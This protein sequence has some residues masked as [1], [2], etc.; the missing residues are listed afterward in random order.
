MR[1]LLA[2]VM[3]AGLLLPAY[4]WGQR[5]IHPLAVKP[6]TKQARYARLDQYA[7]HLPEAQAA[8]LEKLA[9]SLASQAHTDDDKARLIF[10]WLAYHI[11]YDATLSVSDTTHYYRRCAP[12]YVLQYRKAVCQGYADLF[13]E[14]ATHMKLLAHTITGHS[15]TWSDTGNLLGAAN[16]HAWNTYQIAGSWHLADATWGAGGTLTTTNE[17]QQQFEPF[18]FDTP[19]TQLIFSH[20]PDST[21]WQML[22]TFITL[23]AFQT[24]PYVEPAWFQLVNGASL[25][26]T[27]GTS[28]VP[29]SNLPKVTISN[30]AFKV[31]IVQVPL[32]RELVA[33]QPVK[34]IFQAPAEVELSAELD[35]GS[36]IM[37]N[38]GHYHQATI[39]PTNGRINISAW[40]KTDTTFIC[41]LQYEVIPTPRQKRLQPGQ[42]RPAIADSVVYLRP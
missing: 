26:Q 6:E 38:N 32:H 24:W 36:L 29:V 33:G 5:V 34:F 11:A 18:W 30:A 31:R 28:K 14:L 40:H 3:I 21:A 15:R 10:A 8:T 16:G 35:T 42:H 39:T 27:L 13:T 4:G 1:L 20:L 12:D 9:A 41:A 19:P 17:F 7:Q 25:I 2:F 22:P 23:N 37:K